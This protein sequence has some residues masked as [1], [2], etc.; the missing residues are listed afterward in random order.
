[1]VSVGATLLPGTGSMCLIMGWIS[2]GKRYPDSTHTARK[3]GEA[4]IIDPL[5]GSPGITHY[6]SL[7]DIHPTVIHMQSLRDFLKS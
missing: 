6:L 7:W 2:R 4:S 1:M 5:R 3:R